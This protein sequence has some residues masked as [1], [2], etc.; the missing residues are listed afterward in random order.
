MSVLHGAPAVTLTQT[1]SVAERSRVRV[2][3]SDDGAMPRLHLRV[4]TTL[5]EVD[6]A[7][8]VDEAARLHRSVGEA[9]ATLEAQFA[10]RRLEVVR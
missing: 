6:L 9:V 3:T 8:S 1:L 10:P 2:E 5:G 4:L 7:L